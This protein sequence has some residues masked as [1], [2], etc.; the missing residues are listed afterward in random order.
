[1][2]AEPAMP[3][4]PLAHFTLIKEALP[5]WITQASAARMAVLGRAD[6]TL[7]EAF[8]STS[9]DA[10][11]RLKSAVAA[12]WTAQNA[13]DKHLRHLQ[14]AEAFAEPLLKQ[15]LLERYGL[16]EDVRETHLRLYAPANLPWWAHDVTAGVSSR[17]VS[18]LHAAL[19]NFAASETFTADSAFITR[20]DTQGLFDIK[21]I[22]HRITIGQF[23]SLV[24]ELDIGRRYQ[25]H[26]EE[27]L[28]FNQPLAKAVLQAR[29]IRH[30]KAAFKTAVQSALMLEQIDMSTHDLMLRLVENHQG[31]LLNGA[32]LCC[33]DLTLMDTPLTGIVVIAADLNQGRQPRPV[34]VYVPDDPEHPLK[35][36]P[37]GASFVKELTRQ[38]RQPAYQRFFCRFVPQAQRGLFLARLHE[39]LSH[40][41]WQPTRARDPLPSW[42]EAPVDKPHLQIGT[43]RV[44]ADLWDH[45]YQHQLDKILNDAREIAVSTAYADRMARWAWWDNLEHILT[46]VL[47]AAL[48]VATPFMPVL[49]QLMLAYSAWQLADEVFEGLLDWTQGRRV[50]AIEHVV[51]IA[52]SVV[53]LGIFGAGASLGALARVK[54][55]AFVEGLKPV[56][57]ADGRQRLWHPDLAPYRQP[58]LAPV[59]GA[60]PDA[61]GFHQRQEQKIMRLDSHHY[62][63]SQDPHT[64]QYRILHPKRPDAYQPEVFSNGAGTLVHEGEAPMTWDSTRLMQRLTPTTADLT[65]AELARIRDISGTATEEL[66]RIYVECTALPPLLA[67]TLERFELRRAVEGFGDLVRKGTPT[68]ETDDWTAQSLTELPGWPVERAIEVFDAADLSGASMK[69]GD[70]EAGAA[71]TLRISRQAVQA[72]QLPEQIVGYL[73]EGE[74]E[75]LL[76]APLP[77]APAREQALRNR[78]GDYLDTQQAAIFEHRYRLA[79]ASDDTSARLVQQ[80]CPQLP[81]ALVQRLLSRARPEERRVITEEQRLPLRLKRQAQALQLEVQATHAYEGLY[82]DVPLGADTERLLL[83]ALRLYTDTFA[84]LRISVHEH[85]PTGRLRCSVGPEDAGISK[86]LLRIAND[87][88]TLPD[89]RERTFDLYEA[90][91]RLLPDTHLNVLGYRPGQGAALKQWLLAKLLPPAARRVALAQPPLAP[92]IQRETLHLLKW[93]DFRALRQLFG[94]GRS[95]EARIARLYPRMTDEEVRSVATLMDTPQGLSTLEAFENEKNRLAQDLHTWLLTPTASADRALA[96]QERLYRINVGAV[97]RDCWEQRPQDYRSE[98]G[99]PLFGRA[100]DFSGYA[101]QGALKDFPRLRADFGHVTSLNMTGAAM[102]DSDAIF[103]HNFPQLR[104][105]DLTGNRL[106]ELPAQ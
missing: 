6:K 35:H 14:D 61:E 92:V 67:D 21:H 37:D 19:H 60:K 3:A 72:G 57:L 66:Q 96:D 62:A 99:D 52:Q 79:Y 54:A 17:T 33:H 83:N 71:Q 69:Y 68:G 104:T 51:G 98:Y 59:A 93:P 38:L 102:L 22:K 81:D 82:P 64:S 106:T 84:N 39:R 46:D 97:L 28:G 78:L 75:G 1:M 101:L 26:L 95:V 48:L 10:R 77:A 88:Y 73:S 36:Y 50:D 4:T 30:S 2:T 47:N 44:Q 45:L 74:L 105:L 55:S 100:L 15:A 76:G 24:R 85:T 31:L 29:V 7:P 42:R 87:R 27:Q 8:E 56:Q 32:P 20:P 18:L 90:T 12:Q 9:T 40:V 53:Q 43:R 58:E 103:L 91:L 13:V 5:T 25:Q 11:Q 16:D 94:L 49:G 34:L 89:A 41:T 23:K 80:T 65:P 70:R 63:V 86:V